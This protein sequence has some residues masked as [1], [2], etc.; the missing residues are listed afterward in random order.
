M[1]SYAV[2]SIDGDWY[3]GLE[4]KYHHACDNLSQMAYLC[5]WLSTDRII[6]R[7]VFVLSLVWFELTVVPLYLF[8]NFNVAL[9]WQHWIRMTTLYYDDNIVLGWQPRIR[10]TTLYYTLYLWWQLGSGGVT[11]WIWKGSSESDKKFPRVVSAVCWRTILDIRAD[12]SKE[13]NSK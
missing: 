1:M 12:I 7:S 6:Q 3:E 5:H 13:V 4:R 8:S 9:G 11:V 10:M 2:V